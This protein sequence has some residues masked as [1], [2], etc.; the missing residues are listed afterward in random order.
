M[1][2][3][4]CPTLR[5]RFNIMQNNQCSQVKGFTKLFPSTISLEHDCAQTVLPS[6]FWQ[7]KEH[8]PLQWDKLLGPGFGI[9]LLLIS[10]PGDSYIGSVYSGSTGEAAGD[11]SELC[12]ILS[13]YLFNRHCTVN[14]ACS[15]QK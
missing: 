7:A 11:M 12:T 2:T 10:S 6:L 1:E 15:R 14:E 5:K 4:V 13:A 9:I 8:A 3:T